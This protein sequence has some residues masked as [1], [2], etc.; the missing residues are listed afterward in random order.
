MAKNRWGISAIMLVIHMITCLYRIIVFSAA[1][2]DGTSNGCLF[3]AV[4]ETDSLYSNAFIDE[5]MAKKEQS[6]A[7]M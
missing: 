2:L 1:N 3:L 6:V 5:F 7:G 4:L